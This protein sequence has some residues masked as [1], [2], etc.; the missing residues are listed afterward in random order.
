V[1]RYLT[2]AEYF[3]LADQI[4]GVD[5]ET[6]TKAARSARPSTASMTHLA[7]GLSIRA[8]QAVPSG[9]VRPDVGA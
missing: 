7:I 2:L 8:C 1:T 4:T 9:G 3:W 6:L 5:A